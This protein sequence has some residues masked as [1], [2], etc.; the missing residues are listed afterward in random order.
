MWPGRDARVQKKKPKEPQSEQKA[1]QNGAREAL[2]NAHKDPNVQNRLL[3]DRIFM[4]SAERGILNRLNNAASDRLEGRRSDGR[5]RLDSTR[6]EL[7]RVLAATNRGVPEAMLQE[8][9]ELISSTSG[10]S[11]RQNE[12]IE[13]ALILI[14]NVNRHYLARGA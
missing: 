9:E 4:E 12:N 3:D 13:A 8:A 1:E 5:A 2:E 6:T 11:M 7:R 14:S 10:D